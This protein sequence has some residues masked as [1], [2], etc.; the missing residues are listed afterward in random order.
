MEEYFRCKVKI[1]KAG[2]YPVV[3]GRFTHVKSKDDY[4][5]YIL[6]DKK[7]FIYVG[8]TKQSIRA[9]F[10][11]S[12]YAFKNKKSKTYFNGYTGYK[13]IEEYQK[14]KKHLDLIVIPLEKEK[15]MSETIEAELVCLIRNKTGKWPLFQH[16]IHFHNND[17]AEQ[18]AKNIFKS[19]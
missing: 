18:V 15:I 3:G 19:V 7:S 5:L 8:I 16:E 6:K 10:G 11:S 13:W 14:S 9:R 1:T 2:I 17:R 12:F 4:A